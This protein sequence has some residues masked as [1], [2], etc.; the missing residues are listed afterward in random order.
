MGGGG[1]STPDPKFI[2]KVKSGVIPDIN[3]PEGILY[4]A[5]KKLEGQVN[6]CLH[7]DPSWV[8]SAPVNRSPPAATDH[9]SAAQAVINTCVEQDLINQAF[10]LDG[11]DYKEPYD[12]GGGYGSVAGAAGRCGEVEIEVREI[13]CPGAPI[14]ATSGMGLVVLGACLLAG[15]AVKFGR[16]AAA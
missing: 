8:D 7:N 6:S 3:C 2:N 10:T 16:R 11:M 14:P 13:N 1:H 4:E 5:G 15:T 12:S 9:T